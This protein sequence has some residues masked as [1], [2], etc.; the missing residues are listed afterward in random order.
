MVES[1]FCMWLWIVDVDE[2]GVIV[3]CL[4]VECDEES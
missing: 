1:W 3:V 4:L 2:G